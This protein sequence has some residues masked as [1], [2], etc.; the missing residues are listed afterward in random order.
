MTYSHNI[1]KMAQKLIT[2]I[3]LEEFYKRLY[4]D[5]PD[6]LRTINTQGIILTCNFA[7][8]DKLGYSKSEVIGMS[9]FEHISPKSMFEIR[10]SFDAWKKNGVVKNREMWLKR[11]DGSEFPVLLTANNLYDKNGIL[12]GSNT[13]IRDIT[14]IWKIRSE[15]EKKERELIK[16]YLKI[17]KL[18]S[19]KDEFL[20]M[21]THEL[22]TPLVPIKGYTDLLLTE[23]FGILN[24]K[25]KQ[26]LSII[27]S[28]IDFLHSLISDLLDAQ[29]IESGNFKLNKDL[30]DLK[31]I[32]SE[33]VY[34]LKPFAENSSVDIHNNLEPNI[35]CFC[36]KI[37]LKQV[38]TNLITNSVKFKHEQR[39]KI[40]VMLS[41]KGRDAQ[42]IIKDNG[43]GIRQEKLE[44]IF[45]KFYQVDTSLR[46]EYMGV[47]LGLSICKGI[48]E[49]HGG[50]IFA[51]SE[52]P[53]KGAEMFVLLPIKNY[54]NKISTTD[55]VF[56][57][58]CNDCNKEV[59]PNEGD[60]IYG[61]KWHHKECWKTHMTNVELE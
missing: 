17:K 27:T 58:I 9:I 52:G 34:E 8:A 30:H 11:K 50:K 13:T 7:Y 4:D 19:Q 32:I 53:G 40:H 22:K 3:K 49:A 1:E 39:G 57:R 12:V 44:K 38:I 43:I 56:V 33:I 10:D 5:S 24:E 51:K 54:S 15:N 29:K 59:I 21:I 31:E 37:R 25:Q 14:E 2:S 26:T 36:D 23:K 45:G 61:N 20:S 60:V 48:I 35:Y 16:Q 41:R 6:M 28:N 42:I 18:S 46:R 55:S 47:G